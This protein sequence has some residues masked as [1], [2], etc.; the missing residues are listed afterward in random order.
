M[1]AAG[2]TATIHQHN[3]DEAM[4]QHPSWLYRLLIA[5]TF[6]ETTFLCMLLYKC[7]KFK[8]LKTAFSLLLKNTQLSVPHPRFLGFLGRTTH[9]RVSCTLLMFHPQE[10]SSY[11]EVGHKC[12]YSPVEQWQHVYILQQYYTIVTDYVATDLSFSVGLKN[13]F[14]WKWMKQHLKEKI[15]EYS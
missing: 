10:H 3:H 11:Y 9:Y 2:Q 12:C 15:F 5:H 14:K 1:Q 4:L 8:C 13:Y 6:Y 7:V